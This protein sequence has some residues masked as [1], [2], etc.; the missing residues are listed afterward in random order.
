MKKVET[1]RKAPRKGSRKPVEDLGD[2]DTANTSP[3]AQK[4]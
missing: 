3:K 4:P 2:G 1:K